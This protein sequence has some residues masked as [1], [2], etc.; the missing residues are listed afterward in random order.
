LTVP[1]LKVLT[2]HIKDK[3]LAIQNIIFREISNSFIRT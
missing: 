1:D 2:W 3:L